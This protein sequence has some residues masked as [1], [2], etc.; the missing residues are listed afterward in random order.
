MAAAPTNDPIWEQKLRFR[1]MDF[2]ATTRKAGTR[3]A[4]T[5]KRKTT[6]ASAGSAAAS[7]TRHEAPRP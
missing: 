4:R 3:A 2:E 5:A 7:Q 6:K 1:L